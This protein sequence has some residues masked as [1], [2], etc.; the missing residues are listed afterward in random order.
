MTGF[1]QALVFASLF[2]LV[3]ANV[4]SRHGGVGEGALVT[5]QQSGLVIGVATLG[6]LYLGLDTH[7]IS[8][9]FTATTAAMTAI[10]AVLV[11]TSRFIHGDRGQPT[12]LP[13]DLSTD[14]LMY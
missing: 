11:I 7:S 3:L 9:A 12:R 4:P 14:Q 6:T 2:R 13:S 10:L 8:E 1:G 5:I